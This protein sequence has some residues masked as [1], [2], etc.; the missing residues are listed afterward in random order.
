M[1]VAARK[2]ARHSEACGT[3]TVSTT[4]TTAAARRCRNPQSRGGQVRSVFERR[5]M[6]LQ[7]APVGPVRQL[8]EERSHLPDGPSSARGSQEVQAMQLGCSRSCR[9]SGAGSVRITADCS[10]PRRAVVQSAASGFK[11]GPSTTSCLLLA[12]PFGGDAISLEKADMTDPRTAHA[13]SAAEKKAQDE[14]IPPAPRTSTGQEA[15]DGT[16]RFRR[17]ED[18][19]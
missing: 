10:C 18:S 12:F 6:P 16:P 4:R 5:A 2:P 7:P 9:G 14:D 17:A 19:G 8:D 3:L 15:A 13:R 11:P 1:P